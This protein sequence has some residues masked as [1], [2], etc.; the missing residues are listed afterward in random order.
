VSA[1][2]P[3]TQTARAE[4][5]PQHPEPRTRR[6]SPLLHSQQAPRLA[7]TNAATATQAKPAPT[8]PTPPSTAVRG[9][10]THNGGAQNIANGDMNLAP[11]LADYTAAGSLRVN[12]PPAGICGDLLASLQRDG[13]ALAQP[14]AAWHEV[15]IFGHRQVRLQAAAGAPPVGQAYHVVT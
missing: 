1:G 9:W 4:A 8:L 6:H 2:P 7:T 12:N 3:D 14:T 11:Y 5:V 15:G 13:L 10:A